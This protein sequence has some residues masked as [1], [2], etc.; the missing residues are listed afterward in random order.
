MAATLIPLAEYL[1]TTY[2]PDREYVEGVTL[3][4]N[5]GEYDHARLQIVL[6]GWLLRH[7]REWNIR[8]VVE[9]RVQ[10]SAARFRVPDVTVLSREQP[11]EQIISKAPLVVIE[12]LSKDDTWRGIEEKI[13]DYL[14][15]GI[16]NIWI[17]DPGPR[18]A[19]IAARGRLDEIPPEGALLVTGTPICLRLAE[20]FQ[21]LD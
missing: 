14:D 13:D 12:V 4:R 5:L 3:E 19:W 10:V 6:A 18:R 8:V 15:F 16:P 9:Q 17:L 21:E 11:I 1:A 20:L 2:H 7:E